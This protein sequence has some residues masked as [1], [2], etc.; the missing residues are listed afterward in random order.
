GHAS[1]WSH[2]ISAQTPKLTWVGSITA[3]RQ[4]V[5]L[6]SAVSRATA[7]VAPT[8]YDAALRAALREGIVGATL[9]VALETAL[10]SLTSCLWAVIDHTHVSFGVC[11]E[12]L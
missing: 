7:R 5:K 6:W 10:H 11:A 8:I 12:V 9:A 1:A 4:E 2:S 3:Q